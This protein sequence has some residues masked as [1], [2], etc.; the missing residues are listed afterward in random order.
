MPNMGA[1]V[2]SLARLLRSGSKKG[3]DLRDRLGVS[4]PTLS[5]LMER[6]Q[7]ERPGFLCKIGA[8]RATRYAWAKAVDGDPSRPWRISVYRVD[9]QGTLLPFGALTVLEA[10]EYIFTPGPG[11][12]SMA[13]RLP[14]GW[15]R[16]HYEGIPWFLQD[17][18]YQGYLGRALAQPLF[19]LRDSALD[20]EE[21]S[22]HVHE[23]SDHQ[24][25][26]LLS[27]VGEDLPGNFLIGVSSAVLFGRQKA[28]TQVVAIPER[29]AV[30]AQRVQDLVTGQWIPHSS[31]GGEQPKFT[32][33]VADAS[34]SVRQ[35]IVK[36]SPP[37]QDKSPVARR[38]CD[39]LRAE[40]HALSV[41]SRF[42]VP[43][44]ATDI[45]Q[46]SD[47]R[48]FL[49]STRFDRIGLY[50]RTPVFS[51]RFILMEVLGDLPGWATAAKKLHELG[52]IDPDTE[53]RI[54]LLDA[55]GHFIGNTDRHSGNL[56]F[57]PGPSAGSR[58]FVVAPVYDMLPM[59]YAPAAQGSVVPGFK[60]ISA[61]V[62]ED[63]LIS[64]AKDLARLFWGDVARDP[65]I[66]QDF[67]E[68]ATAHMEALA[69]DASE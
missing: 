9:G 51:M 38:W 5:R 24:V 2:D 37:A 22:E 19:A 69:P 64:L 56:S 4:P 8:A 50:G 36:F 31:V 29:P 30:Y 62:E 11:A 16:T 35:V 34:G 23:W 26:R 20:A 12:Q 33:C 28:E 14:K 63:A 3:Q 60:D 46:G 65:H 66:S 53:E 44:A 61:Y 6:C 49:E 54:R 67:R 57:M 17:L 15:V 21:L 45:V 7:R 58:T 25:L 1:S 39:L 40:F 47:G 48:W 32:A 52:L 43:T 68:M 10:D 18:R 59:Q 27:R 13:G 42:G 41:L 55:Y